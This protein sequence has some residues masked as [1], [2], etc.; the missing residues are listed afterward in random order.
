MLA[1]ELS[2]G[3]DNEDNSSDE[4]TVNSGGAY[5]LRDPTNAYNECTPVTECPSGANVRL[6]TYSVGGSF[7]TKS[8]AYYIPRHLASH[9]T[10]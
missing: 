4:A 10:V 1:H 2:F 9:L 7:S 6:R 3:I 8:D 5:W